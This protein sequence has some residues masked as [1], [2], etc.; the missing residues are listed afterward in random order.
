MFE[1]P[2]QMS[3]AE[4]DPV[5]T[6]WAEIAKLSFAPA[7]SFNINHTDLAVANPIIYTSGSNEPGMS[8]TVTIC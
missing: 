4:F 2:N 6:K 1:Y 3:L 7:V 8:C 5:T